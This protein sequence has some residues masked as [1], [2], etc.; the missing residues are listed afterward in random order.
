V[1][2]ERLAQVLRDLTGLDAA[3]LG[4]GALPQAVAARRPGASSSVTALAAYADEVRR[5][6][7]A[8]YDL[9]ADLLVHETSFFRYPA[10]FTLLAERV[11]TVLSDP[12]RTVRVLSAPC[13]TGQEP[14]SV[15]MALIEAGVPLER[16]QLDAADLSPAVVARARDGF[17]GPGEARGLDPARRARFAVREGGGWRLKPDIV[18]LVS[19]SVM[20]LLDPAFGAG[21]EPYDVILCR[22]LLIYLTPE[23]RARLFATLAHRLGPG[24]VLL[25]GHAEIV[26]ARDAG[27]LP[28][29]PPEAYCVTRADAHAPERPGTPVSRADLAPRGKPPNRRADAAGPRTAPA[30]APVR[31]PRSAPRTAPAPEPVLTQA[32]RLADLGR[33][34]EALGLLSAEERAGRAGPDHFHLTA[35]LYRALARPEDADLA[36]TRALYL[37]S[38]HVPA[39]RLA[40]LVAGEQG[41]GEK[42]ARLEARAERA[43]A[44]TA[45]DAAPGAAAATD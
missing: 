12:A 35:V 37:D 15:A 11:R 44:T 3:A 45:R 8:R 13:S 32:R 6:P 42:A 19:Y 28:Y 9:V 18:G 21:L 14:A 17:Y 22:N 40:A 24:G 26:P 30:A 7:A 2:L 41:D 33:L 36:L 43:A 39:L 31:A 29:G 20:D 38:R 23:A 4:S 10:A 25:L 5:D 1:S 16:V 27:F 34:D